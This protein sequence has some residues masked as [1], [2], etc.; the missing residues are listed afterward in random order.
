MGRRVVK[1]TGTTVCPGGRRPSGYESS[2]RPLLDVGDYFAEL[3][4]LEAASVDAF[5]LLATELAAH[6]APFA[7]VRRARRA[8]TDERRHARVVAAL[9][10]RWGRSVQETRP[11]PHGS[12][13]L[14]ELARENVVEGC[15]R[16]TYA[17]LLAHTQAAQSS[18]PDVAA[19][20]A[21]IAKDETRHGQLAW[22]VWAW[23][24]TRLTEAEVGVISL[25][26]VAAARA[27]HAELDSPMPNDPAHVLGLPTSAQAQ[28]LL[29]TLVARLRLP[30]LAA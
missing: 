16:E 14:M 19:A 1:C 22:D 20:L 7:L 13:S 30:A 4:R 17:A 21:R 24:Q 25:D 18:D 8:A 23:T 2:D 26:A 3:A 6:G 10:A 28:W 29:T 27:L 15:I 9:A 5:E 12:R 11:A